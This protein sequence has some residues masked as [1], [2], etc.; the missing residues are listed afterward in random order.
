VI[1]GRSDD[2]QASVQKFERTGRFVLKFRTEETSPLAF[3]RLVGAAV[4]AAGNVYALDA[5]AGRVIKM[6]L[7]GNYLFSFASFGR[8]D[9][10]LV[11]PSGIT[12]SPFGGMFVT[13]VSQSATRIQRFTFDG[14]FTGK[15]GDY[16][17]PDITIDPRT[18]FVLVADTDHDQVLVYLLRGPQLLQ[19]FGHSGS[20][21]GEFSQLNGIAADRQFVYVAD[22]GNSRV[23]V[24]HAQD[25]GDPYEFVRSVTYQAERRFS[26]RGIAPVR[27]GFVVADVGN[28]QLV[29]FTPDGRVDR[30]IGSRGQG[31]GQFD[32]VQSVAAD[33]EG[34]L[35]ATD[36]HTQLV[37]K[38]S[39]DGRFLYS[40]G[41]EGMAP[42]NLN[43]PEGIHITG[44]RIY[45][46][47]AFNGRVAVF[48]ED[49]K[50]D[51]DG[52]GLVGI[53]DLDQDGDGIS[54][55]LEGNG[56]RDTDG[57]GIP[58][59]LDLDSD[60][61]GICDVIEV[62]LPATDDC[63]IA[64]T[65]DDNGNG[66]ADS[67]DPDA[68]GTALVPRDTDGDGVPDYLDGDSDNDGRCDVSETR[69]GV[70]ANHDCVYDHEED[71]NGDGL[72]DA[73]YVINGKPLVLIDSNRDGLPN[74]I[75][76]AANSSSSSG[77]GGCAI[78][79]PVAR[80][81]GWCGL[82]LVP[83]LFLLRRAWPARRK[84]TE[85]RAEDPDSHRPVRRL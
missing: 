46:V 73:L 22:R 49:L 71:L 61:D 68:G 14:A 4:D 15:F 48:A 9:G 21:D 55:E 54:D 62:G 42:N 58:D 13:D 74:T 83:A 72:A 82:S 66:L 26:P 36:N 34:G 51:R 25:L 77:G 67:V 41:G 75:D 57:D 18:N 32:N 50:R 81:A 79:A 3:R 6:D 8:D 80:P 24:F 23:Q 31:D 28:E 43:A 11:L 1:D 2:Q 64:D 5:D 20:G 84:R 78:V 19:T 30:I 76:A 63:H 27:G 44:G 52:D 53:Y 17:A 10:Q 39:P 29:K 85:R 70:D 7:L 16:R 45:V 59:N 56:D 37:Q 35:Y 12:S 60:Q 40:F 33:S 47:D 65:R 38:F 69:G